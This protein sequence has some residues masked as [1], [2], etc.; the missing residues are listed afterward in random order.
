MY[1]KHACLLA[2]HQIFKSA[3]TKSHGFA[4][5]CKLCIEY[6]SR[7]PFQGTTTLWDSPVFGLPQPSRCQCLSLGLGIKVWPKTLRSL[8]PI[9]EV[10]FLVYQTLAVVKAINQRR[11]IPCQRMTEVERQSSLAIIANGLLHPFP[12]RIFVSADLPTELVLINLY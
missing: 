4:F 3:M 5:P 8:Q 7:Y 10:A 1:S 2:V 12:E 11:S 6:T 9:G